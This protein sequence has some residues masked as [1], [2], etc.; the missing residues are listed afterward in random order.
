MV[1]AFGDVAKRAENPKQVV[2]RPRGR[3]GRMSEGTL[4]RRQDE[5]G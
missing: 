5:E 2:L 4:K 3:S 1:D